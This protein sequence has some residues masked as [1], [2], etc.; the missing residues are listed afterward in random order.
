MVRKVDAYEAPDGTWTIRDVP[1]FA[2]HRAILAPDAPGGDPETIDV[3]RAYL[4]RMRMLAEAR[5][6]LDG[7]IGP[8]HVNHTGDANKHGAS[9]YGG[10][11]RLRRVGMMTFEG[12]PTELLFSD[13]VAMPSGIYERVKSGELAYISPQVDFG[14]GEMNSIAL[15]DHVTP[16]FRFGAIR[17]GREFR[18]SA[19]RKRSAPKTAQFHAAQKSRGWAVS[20]HSTAYHADGRLLVTYSRTQ[21]EVKFEDP[22]VAEPTDPMESPE[23]PGPLDVAEETVVDEGDDGLTLDELLGE[24]DAEEFAADEPAPELPANDKIVKGEKGD[25][26]REIGKL[27]VEMQP[28]AQALADR[29]QMLMERNAAL[30]ARAEAGEKRSQYARVVSKALRELTPMGYRAERIR[31]MASH[32]LK[33]GGVAA[34]AIYAR[35]LKEAALSGVHKDPNLPP[36]AFDDLEHEA[37]TIDTVPATYSADARQAAGLYARDYIQLQGSGAKLSES[38]E[39]FVDRN[40]VA[41][42]K[43][44]KHET[45]AAVAARNGANGAGGK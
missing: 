28:F 37:E 33:Q 29:S 4:E 45:R 24:G 25:F 31:K 32:Y 7:Y 42:R 12:R 17:I 18:Q 11:W 1:V 16:H 14:D 43:L 9:Y 22:T 15:M 2:E 36:E 13:L 27:P 19:A 44:A 35:T 5:R 21:R 6:K 26:A 8:T 23:D 39:Q 34:F 38:L 41:A 10:R 30:E 40:L 3:D 20:R